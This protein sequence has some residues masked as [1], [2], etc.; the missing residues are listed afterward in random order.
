MPV[1]E[2]HDGALT[3][4]QLGNRAPHV[5][6]WSSIRVSV[7]SDGEQIALPASSPLPVQ[8]LCLVADCTQQISIKALDLSPVRLPGDSQKGSVVVMS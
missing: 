3:D 1:G 8:I 2:E 7:G 5:N 4:A 6:I